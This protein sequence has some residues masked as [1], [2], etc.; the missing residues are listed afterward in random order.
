[1]MDQELGRLR[2]D[3]SDYTTE[4]PEGACGA[5]KGMPD[6]TKVRAFIPGTIVEL[7]VK[8]GEKVQRGT[9]LLLLDAMKMHNEVCSEMPGR[10]R[11]VLVTVGASVQK[12]QLMVEL[13]PL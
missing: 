12:N 8:P 13:E 6:R 9:I 7:R 11:A 5:F 10:V 3:D 1:M 2:V 4:V